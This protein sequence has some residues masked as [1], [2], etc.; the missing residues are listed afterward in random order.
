PGAPA[1]LT[2]PGPVPPPPA[3]LHDHR[4][5]GVPMQSRRAAAGAVGLLPGPR[6]GS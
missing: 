1:G 6:S 4:D 3:L 5:G 2:G